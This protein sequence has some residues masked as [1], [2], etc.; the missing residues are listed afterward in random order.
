MNGEWLQDE[1]G[2]YYRMD[3]K[4]KEYRP[5]LV[6]THG[7]LFADEATAQIQKDKQQEYNRLAEIRKKQNVIS[8]GKFCPFRRMQQKLHCDCKRNCEFYRE[9]SCVFSGNQVVQVEKGGFCPIAGTCEGD[10]C[11]LYS[12]GCTLTGIREAVSNE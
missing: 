10:L 3:G 9:T 2:R 8:T 1:H 12:G 11:S 4:I 6:T 7:T 5:T